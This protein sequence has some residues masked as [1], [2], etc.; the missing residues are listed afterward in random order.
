MMRC[1][2]F[3]LNIGRG[4]QSMMLDFVRKYYNRHRQGSGMVDI[5]GSIDSPARAIAKAATYQ[6][7]HDPRLIHLGCGDKKF[8]KW[9]NVD[10]GG[11]ADVFWDFNRPLDFLNV[12]SWD[13]CFSEHVLEHFERP[14]AIRLCQSVFR[15][16]RP[17]GVF[18]IA[19]PDLDRI[20]DR[21]TRGHDRNTYAAIHD[22][23][24]S[25]YG[26]IFHTKGELIDICFRGWG[27]KYL[28]NFED[29]HR[30]L[31]LAGFSDVE[32]VAYHESRFDFMKTRETRA[33][34]QSALIV[35]AVK[36]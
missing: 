21:Y 10:I 23:F 15:A 24:R 7:L 4:Y 30:L 13:G 16:L 29:L 11:V 31:R 20:I 1:G 14:V 27:H 33:P 9:L 36:R 34:E 3:D 12:D 19:I 35:E 17:G 8:L 26:E 25:Y 2:R 5:S 32:R 6:R 18:R 28:Y 22:E